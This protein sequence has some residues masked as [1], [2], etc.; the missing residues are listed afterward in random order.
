MATT[1]AEA[2]LNAQDDVDVQVIDEFRKSSDILDRMTFDNVVSPTGGDTL[3]YGYRRLI[4]ERGADFR[5]INAEYTSAEVTSQR[6][7][8][9]LVP[10]G[11]SFK[12]DRVVARIGPAASGA[13]TLNM[14]QLIKASRAKFADAVINGDTA[15]DANGFNGLSKIL[16]G[17]ATEYLPLTNGVSLGYVDWTTV[18][19]KA[20]ALAEMARLDAWLSLMDDRPDVIYGNRKTLALFKM[21]AAW[22]DQIDKTTDAFG[23]P[24]VAYNGIPLVDLGAKAGSN[25]DV[26]GLVSRDADG[27]GA[28]GSIANLGDLY[29]VRYG[30][31]GFHGA[32]VGGGAPLLS[33]YLPDF[34]TAGAVKTGE[35]ELGPVAPVL[36]AT[37]SAA[38]FRN[39]KSA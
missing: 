39:I 23:R 37:K 15:V 9:D 17:T 11:G 27:G 12:V 3:T 28:G 38:V 21:L 24:V 5:A 13:V 8:V 18:D 32:S 26:I 7:T 6:Y 20:E 31:D 36:K 30:L 4:T 19:T 25:T 1:L 29:A 10:L 33:T 2:K 14:Q 16:T 34:T 35:V 22:A